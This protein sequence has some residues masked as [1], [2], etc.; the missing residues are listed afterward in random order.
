MKHITPLGSEYALCGAES[1]VYI[2]GLW[3]ENKR[4]Y[5]DLCETCMLIYGIDPDEDCA[6]SV[7]TV[8]EAQRLTEGF[9]ITHASHYKG[10]YSYTCGRIFL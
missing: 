8:L 10:F 5:M 7:R 2:G 4:L 6:I 3:T 9:M 1:P